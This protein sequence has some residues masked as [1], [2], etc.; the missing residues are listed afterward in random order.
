VV[1]AA[2]KHIEQIGHHGMLSFLPHMANCSFQRRLVVLGVGS[3][4][5]P[6]LRFCEAA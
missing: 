1:G 6:R 4:G 2:S 5:H 3:P